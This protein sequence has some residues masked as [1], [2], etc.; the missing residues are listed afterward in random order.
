MNKVV[1]KIPYCIHGTVVELDSGVRGRIR[2]IHEP[3]SNPEKVIES[4]AREIMDTKIQRGLYEKEAAERQDALIEMLNELYYE[5]NPAH[6][7]TEE[8]ME[9]FH[10]SDE[11]QMK[12]MAHNAL[13][14]P[15]VKEWQDCNKKL[16]D[17]EKMVE[18]KQQEYFETCC[19]EN[20]VIN[21]ALDTLEFFLRVVITEELEE[22][23]NWFEKYFP[24]ESEINEKDIRETAAGRRETEMNDKNISLK[25]RPH[26]I[27]YTY[28]GNLKNVILNRKNWDA[29]FR[30]I[31]RDK[32][33]FEEDMEFIIHIRNTPAHARSRFLDDGPKEEFS[34]KFRDTISRIILTEQRVREL[35]WVEFH[36]FSGDRM[37]SVDYSGYIHTVFPKV[38]GDEIRL[39]EE[40][41]AHLEIYRDWITRM[42]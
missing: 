20:S 4:G 14:D 24:G 7:Q 29:H 34:K 16:L 33:K 23:E 30:K 38:S 18:K 28:P 35:D 6:L 40:G 19:K 27:H 32:K 15:I 39:T 8:E 17:F 31:F 1:S 21:S 41:R 22:E 42:E 12:I 13:H 3:D 37:R 25:T 11:G 26:L 9:K 2:A 5:A 10:S 36:R